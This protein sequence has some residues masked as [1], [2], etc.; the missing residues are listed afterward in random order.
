MGWHTHL[1]CLFVSAVD[2]STKG[3]GGLGL[4]VDTT[5]QGWLQP[6]LHQAVVMP[7]GIL[8]GPLPVAL[9]VAACRCSIQRLWRVDG[10]D[11]VPFSRLDVNCTG[12]ACAS[13]TLTLADLSSR[14]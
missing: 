6:A 7:Q 14:C 10:A 5:N 2:L 4:A 11:A 12:V 8:Q 13:D 1:N 9:P 3:W